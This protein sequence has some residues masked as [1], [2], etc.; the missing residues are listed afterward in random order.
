MTNRESFEL[1]ALMSGERWVAGQRIAVIQ[2][3]VFKESTQHRSHRKQKSWNLSLL[4]GAFPGSSCMLALWVMYLR[5]S[6]RPWPA[7]GQ[8]DQHRSAISGE[9]S[10]S[11]IKLP[12]Q[13]RDDTCIWNEFN[14]A[15]LAP[16]TTDAS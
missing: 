1:V 8:D 3:A 13:P 14:A 10:A 12:I 2:D 9:E 4:L 7:A 11:S 6:R 15:L 16:H 5:K